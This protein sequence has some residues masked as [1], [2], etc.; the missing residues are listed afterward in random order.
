[1]VTNYVD[2]S[3]LVTVQL[4]MHPLDPQNKI[5][6]FLDICHMLK[7]VRNTLGTGGVF[8]EQDGNKI[9]W[10]C[11]VELQNLQE[12]EGLRLGNKLKLSHIKW[13]Q[14]KMKVNLAAQTLSTSVADAI[15]HCCQTLKLEQFQGSEA[16]GKFVHIF[17]HLFDILN[18]RN[19]CA[20]GNK[21]A[22]PT[23]NKDV[24]SPSLDEAFKYVLA[25]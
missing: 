13:Q 18:S 3:T 2:M 25:L 12:E 5:F 19:P 20:K 23:D 8:I 6:V 15:E 21:L 7:L 22:L 4:M 14:Q 1:M 24:W 10:Q 9:L 11:F 17:D 16:T